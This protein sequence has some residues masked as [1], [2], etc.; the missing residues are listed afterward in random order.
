MMIFT[1]IEMFDVGS[2]NK[3]DDARLDLERKELYFVELDKSQNEVIENCEGAETQADETDPQGDQ[4]DIIVSP[5]FV[6]SSALFHLQSFLI[7]L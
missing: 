2:Q 5:N 1:C 3:S 4:S 6:L 7:K